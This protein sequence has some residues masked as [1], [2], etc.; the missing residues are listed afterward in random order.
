MHA[1]P[2]TYSCQY[3]YIWI[4]LLLPLMAHGKSSE[5]W[6]VSQFRNAVGSSRLNWD[7]CCIDLCAGCAGCASEQPDRMQIR[8]YLVKTRRRCHDAAHRMHIAMNR[9]EA[10]KRKIFFLSFFSISSFIVIRAFCS[11]IR[12]CSSILSFSRCLFVGVSC[13][14]HIHRSTSTHEHTR[15]L[16]VYMI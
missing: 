12:G 5:A 10:Q 15:S 3:I 7:C 1:Q 9:T 13:C 6:M 8:I 16:Y 2:H 14:A 11:V 4:N